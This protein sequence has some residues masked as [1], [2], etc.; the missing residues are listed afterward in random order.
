MYALFVAQKVLGSIQTMHTKT[1][2][3]ENFTVVQITGTKFYLVKLGKLQNVL[4]TGET[5]IG[6]LKENYSIGQT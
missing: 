6:L 2:M 3:S 1:K 4:G 5:N